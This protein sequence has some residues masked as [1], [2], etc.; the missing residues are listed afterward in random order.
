MEFPLGKDCL[1]WERTISVRHVAKGVIISQNDHFVE[2]RGKYLFQ[3]EWKNENC[4][5]TRLFGAVWWS[6]KGSG[7]FW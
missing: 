2:G 4:S 6:R 7:G 3:I 1:G 5:R